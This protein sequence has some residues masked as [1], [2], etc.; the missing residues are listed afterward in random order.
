MGSKYRPNIKDQKATERF[1]QKARR[2]AAHGPVK[3]SL[4]LSGGAAR[5][6]PGADPSA[7]R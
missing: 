6:A 7:K 4:F 2:A 1:H 5:P 3:Q